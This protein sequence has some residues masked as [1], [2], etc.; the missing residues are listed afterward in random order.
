MWMFVL[1][2]SANLPVPMGE[3]NGCTGVEKAF[4][5]IH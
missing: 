4:D 1:V 5:V 3:N 2:V